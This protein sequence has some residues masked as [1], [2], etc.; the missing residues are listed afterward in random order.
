MVL[1]KSLTRRIDVKAITHST[2][3]ARLNVAARLPRN[4]NAAV[5]LG[6]LPREKDNAARYLPCP[7]HGMWEQNVMFACGDSRRGLKSSSPAC[8]TKIIGSS[9][10]D[11]ALLRGGSARRSVM[12]RCCEWTSLPWSGCHSAVGEFITA[13][14]DS[15][16][17]PQLD[18]C[19]ASSCG[20]YDGSSPSFNQQRNLYPWFN[21]NIR[22]AQF[23]TLACLAIFATYEAALR[24]VPRACGGRV[25]VG[26]WG[27]WLKYVGNRKARKEFAD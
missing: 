15:H 26:I 1:A 10:F 3:P 24:P 22:Y 23:F 21:A 25:A 9:W 20:S 19:D 18:T 8:S 4:F 2:Q 16:W 13:A 6:R 5:S 7:T 12:W 27:D 17:M 14:P 11:E